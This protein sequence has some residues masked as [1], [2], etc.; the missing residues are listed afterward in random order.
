MFSKNY[1]KMVFDMHNNTRKDKEIEEL[2]NIIL[3][4]D[5]IITMSKE[6]FF[7][8]K[9]INVNNRLSFDMF[10]NSEFIKICNFCGFLFI[11]RSSPHSES[12]IC[13]NC[14]SISR[15]RVVFFSLLNFFYKSDNILINNNPLL[16]D[17]VILEFSPRFNPSKKRIYDSTFFQYI[18]SDFEMKAHRGNIKIDLTN[19]KDIDE[20][21]NKFDIIICSHVVE[22]I[23]DYELALKNL[24][25]LIGA[26]GVLLFQ[27]PIVEANYK[28]LQELEYHGDNTKVFHRFGFDIIE[29]LKKYFKN[30]KPVVGEIDFNILS[31]EI[32][33]MKYEVL[34]KI[35]DNPTIIGHQN[36]IDYGLGNLDLC[37]CFILYN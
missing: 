37:D 24:S 22:H 27:V 17:K 28:L 3:E 33:T 2:K 12:Q 20:N 35:D 11:D 26:K 30:V 25:V 6:T 29:K 34:K 5:K 13:P 10:E 9:Q 19:S 4:K 7:F 23:E 18:S 8:L 31:S 36:V 1:E 21:K 16:K 15:E 14:N 32:D